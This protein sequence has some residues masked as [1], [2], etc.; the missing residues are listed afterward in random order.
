MQCKERLEQFLRENGV[1]FEI[2]HHP[3]AYTAQEV[4]ASEHVPG[5]MFAKTVMVM[6]DGNLVMLVLPASFDVHFARTAGALGAQE[7]RLAT[8]DEFSGIFPDCEIG[9][10]PPFGNLYGLP[11]WADRTLEQEETIVFR[12]GTHS[13]TISMSYGDFA[14]LAAPRIADIAARAVPASA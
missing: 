13:D 3:T 2:Q 1:S 10:E 14:R 11:V 9:A 4:A 6:A 12:A 7:V 8:E 5:N